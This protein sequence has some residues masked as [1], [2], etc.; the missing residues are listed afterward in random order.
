MREGVR[1]RGPMGGTLRPSIRQMPAQVPGGGSEIPARWQAEAWLAAP[2]RVW[3]VSSF[4]SRG[5][6]F[7]PSPKKLPALCGFPGQGAQPQPAGPPRAPEGRPARPPAGH[8]LCLQLAPRPLLGS[9]TPAPPPNSPRLT[10]KARAARIEHLALVFSLPAVL[11][12]DRPVKKTHKDKK[13]LN[14]PLK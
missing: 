11:L 13:Q 2:R 9:P 4:R 14:T 3:S 1:L 12:R 8:G 7:N 10:R 5:G 6:Q